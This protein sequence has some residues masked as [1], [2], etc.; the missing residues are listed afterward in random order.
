MART[1]GVLLAKD[2]L[3]ERREV[4]KSRAMSLVSGNFCALSDSCFC[5]VFVSWCEF[6]SREICDSEEPS[7]AL[8]KSDVC[9]EM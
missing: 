8:E 2:L 5:L 6:W 3:T 4:T 9:L 1:E 7:D